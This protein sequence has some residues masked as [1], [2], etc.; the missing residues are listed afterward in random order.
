M[1]PRPADELLPPHSALRLELF[2]RAAA[3]RGMR[4]LDL[5]V[6]LSNLFV[7]MARGGRRAG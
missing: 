5:R 3:S 6:A 7:L 2:A 4:P 1:T